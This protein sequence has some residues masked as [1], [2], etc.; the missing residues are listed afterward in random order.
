MILANGT[1]SEVA[2]T[3]AVFV[4][5]VAAS[6]ALLITSSRVTTSASAQQALQRWVRIRARHL[7][8]GWHQNTHWHQF[9]RHERCRRAERNCAGRQFCPGHFAQ[10]WC[11]RYY[12]R[13][14][15]YRTNATGS[16]GLGHPA[17]QGITILSATLPSTGNIIG[18]TTSTGRNIISSTQ[19]G[20][21]LDG[22]GVSDNFVRGNYIGTLMSTAQWPFP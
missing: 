10:R 11:Y 22:A 12:D 7:G 14:Q 15:L 8:L 5:Q 17:S 4:Q 20:I 1:S 21:I 19:Q 9:R 13:R 3:A 2:A 6:A 16:V 18:G